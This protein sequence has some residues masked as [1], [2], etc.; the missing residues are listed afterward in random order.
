MED[1]VIV[2]SYQSRL[3]AEIAKGKLA[4]R[5]IASII[6]AD[7]LGGMRPGQSS[8][9]ICYVM[10]KVAK[11]NYQKAQKILGIKSRV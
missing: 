1:L 10:L 2:E 7:D 5:G 9:G 4:S 11:N 3:L 6:F 8:N